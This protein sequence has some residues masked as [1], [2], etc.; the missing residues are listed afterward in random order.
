MTWKIMLMWLAI[1]EGEPKL[2]LTLKDMTMMSLASEKTT[3]SQ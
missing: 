2:C 1:E 3:L